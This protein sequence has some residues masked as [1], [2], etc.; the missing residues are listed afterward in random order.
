MSALAHLQDQP[1]AEEDVL[2]VDFDNLSVVNAV[3]SNVGEWGC[4]LS[5]PEIQELGKNIGI[6]LKN[7]DK[8]VKS[9]ITS[10]KD[11]QATVLFIK[12]EGG[13]ADKRR[14]RRNDVSI[15]VKISDFDGITEIAG[16]IV[17]AGN[18]GCR[19][20][21]KSLKALPNEVLLLMK[22]FGRPVV[23]EFAWRND[24]SGGLK[25]LWD[26]KVG[27]DEAEDTEQ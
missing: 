3:I 23:A 20:M 11:N 4:R 9:Q 19:V 13:F 5:S 26:R 27:G 14:E 22:K 24:T 16:T 8:L 10:R 18:N 17:D 7:S 1:E 2:V 12:S 6:R 21:A 15:P 25:L